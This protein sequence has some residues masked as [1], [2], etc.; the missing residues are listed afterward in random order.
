MIEY[1]KLKEKKNEIEGLFQSNEIITA[2]L[3]L[4]EYEKIYPYDMDILN[5]K[6]FI[7]CHNEEYE[8]AE[9]ILK[10][11]YDKYEYNNEINYNLATIY[12]Y[13]KEYSEAL[14]FL[15]KAVILDENKEIPTEELLDKLL[16]LVSKE[17]FEDIKHK[18]SLYFANMKRK[19][20]IDV[21]KN[22]IEERIKNIHY[23]EKDYYCAIYDYYFTERDGLEIDKNIQLI[24]FNKYEIMPAKKTKIYNG[25][26]NNETVIPLIAKKED[27]EIKINVDGKDIELK[28][29]MPERYY[30]YKFNKGEKVKISSKEEFVI[31]KRIEMKKDEKLPALVL[32]IFIDGL[33]QEF[34]KKNDIKKIAPNIYN[35]FKKGTICNEA[36]TAGEWT[37]TSLA[38]VFTGKATSSHRVFHPKYD[39]ENLFKYEL[40]SEVF[41]R[42]GFFN[43]KIDSDYRSN[44]ALGYMKGIDRY[45]YQ[46]STR[47]FFA[48]D[49]ITE[50]IEHLET[51]K[52]KN[53]F[54][55]ICIPDL[56]DIADRCE[57]RISTQVKTNIEYR[58]IDREYVPT[59]RQRKNNQMIERYKIQLDRVDTYLGLLLNYIEENYNSND[60]VVSLISDHGQGFL[61]EGDEFLD[62]E[63]TKVAMMYKGKNIPKG[64]CNELIST[65]DFFPIILK[66]IG[67][68]KYDYKESNV[69]KYFGGE[70]SRNF[71]YTESLYPSS[72]YY[73]AIN[74][75]K[76]EFLFKTK[77]DATDDARINIENNNDYDYILIEKDTKEDKTKEEIELVN[78]Y[79]E[80]VIDHIKEYIII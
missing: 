52:E 42:I 37:Y 40:Y 6:A 73:A 29:L 57:G 79:I 55:W 80:I 2:Q 56:H 1:K 62:K 49:V 7:Y 39:T 61:I 44:P 8:K 19:F 65:M 66:S 48:D 17:E 71:T 50:T 4:N 75:K 30:Y 64:E 78:K 59:V 34:L 11:S 26:F 31:G 46:L 76:Y 15:L 70:T 35:F 5:M 24:G 53:N 45:V 41:Q 74:D 51:F 38:S 77:K 67:I 27:Q 3:K 14:K 23:L 33:S 32:N 58:T 54:L 22:N 69:P 63:R 28:A 25:I 47:G 18:I 12:Y 43:T 16:E 68:E 36:Y 10:S 21:N 72:P 20:P 13:K 60:Y 9:E